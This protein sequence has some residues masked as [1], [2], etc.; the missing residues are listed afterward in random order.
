MSWLRF[1][2]LFLLLICETRLVYAQPVDTNWPNRPIRFIVPFP[3]GAIT[4]L[5][6]RV[7]AAKLSQQLGQ[8][9]IIDNRTGASGEVGAAAIMHAAPD[10]YTIGLATASTHAIAASLNSS[11]AYDPVK[12]FTPISMIGDAPYVLVVNSSLPAQNVADVIRLAKAQPR[13]LNYSTVGPASLAQF[14]GAL[15]SS[16]T[17]VEL[18]PIPYRTATQAVID[19]AE[20]RIQMQFGAIAASL[21]FVRDGRLRALAV[22]SSARVAMLPDVPTMSEAGLANYEAVLWMAL[23]MPPGTPSILVERMNR[24]TREAIA[25]A[26]VQKSLALQAL[27]PRSSTPDELRG[28]ISS[29]IAKWHKI[30]IEAGI[31]PE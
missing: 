10:G 16:M 15:F 28:R 30:A 24:E 5:V 26:G 31:K 9:V 3:A 6:A 14:A 21:P 12:D 20:G 27:L 23:V 4:D 18:T 2:S 1:V 22:T 19:L 17:G 8:P 13:S 25:D 29:D 7:V 11:L